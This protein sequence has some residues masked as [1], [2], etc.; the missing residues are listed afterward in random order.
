MK[1]KDMNVSGKIS[2]QSQKVNKK[3]WFKTMEQKNSIR[4]E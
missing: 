1:T 4:F 3:S 2:V